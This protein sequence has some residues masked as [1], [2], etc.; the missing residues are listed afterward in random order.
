MKKTKN[1]PKDKIIINKKQIID[2]LWR[3][4]ESSDNPAI[5]AINH[6]SLTTIYKMLETTIMSYLTDSDLC[7]DDITVEI[8]PF[9][10]L[11]I[12]RF[13]EPAETK[14]NNLTGK[15]YTKR[16]RTRYVAYI[17]QYWSR[18]WNELDD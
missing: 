17:P 5:K 8:R 16:E 4:L 18:N 6:K 2:E 7:F 13:I 9:R 3:K 12:R 10:G 11:V 1:M 14:V 15:V